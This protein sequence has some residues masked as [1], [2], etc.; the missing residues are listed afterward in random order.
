MRPHLPRS[1]RFKSAS[2]RRQWIS[3]GRTDEAQHVFDEDSGYSPCA[4]RFAVMTEAGIR[5]RLL[6]V[7]LFWPKRLR[8][9]FRALRFG[10]PSRPI[11]RTRG[12]PMSQQQWKPGDVANGHVL[13]QDGVWRPLTSPPRAAWYQRPVPIIGLAMGVVFLMGGIASALDSG[14]SGGDRDSDRS[15]V[16]SDPT[17]APEAEELAEQLDAEELE[18]EETAV[19]APVAKSKPKPKPKPKPPRTYVVARVVDGDT[20]ELGN[21]Q[22][23]RLVG[24]DTPERGQ[25]G[26]QQAT[27]NLAR[28]VF[29][30]RVRLTISDED[31][32]RYGRLLRYVDVGEVDAGLRQ[33]QGGLAIARY[34][35]RDGYGF[36]AREPRYIRSDKGT[37]QLT[38]PKPQPTPE[39]EPQS[40][41]QNDCMTGYSPCLPI[42]DDLD[43]GEIGHPVTVTGSDPYG[44]DRDGDGVGCDS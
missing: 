37:Q 29:H 6:I 34:D 10:L 4:L 1:A 11:T 15:A 44:L 23:V 43:C 17:E 18:E 40:V 20:L 36:H 39:P 5:P 16:V 25:C 31:T 2:Y 30:K 13:G 35:S 28:V 21:G 9:R 42:T 38:C 41:P 19:T 32:D 27:E 26:Y 33:I 22:T 24:I 3:T 12:W 14:D 7:I 8:R